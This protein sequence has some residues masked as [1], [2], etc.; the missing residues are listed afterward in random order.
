MTVVNGDNFTLISKLFHGNCNRNVANSVRF[1]SNKLPY[2]KEI[3]NDHQNI[4]HGSC[5]FSSQI[6]SFC[7][8]NTWEPEENI[9]D[10]RLFEEFDS[11]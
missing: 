4:I 6:P 11:M 5:H 3:I 7:R 8:H 1:I 9:L 2:V 10:A